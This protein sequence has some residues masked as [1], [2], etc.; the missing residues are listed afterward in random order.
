DVVA[1]RTNGDRCDARPRALPSDTTP[2]AARR[3]V[4]TCRVKRLGWLLW[5]DTLTEARSL[6]RLG[7]L[8]LF[9]IVTL[10]T[11]SFSLPVDSSAR[12]LVGAGF[13]WVAIVFASVLEFRRSFESERKDGTLDGLRAA[14]LDTTL[15]FI[16]KALST[17][18]VVAVV[19][20][21]L[22]PLTALFFSG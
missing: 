6:E 2:D 8:V 11:L 13:I 9:A 21:A 12:K 15:L 18:V 4:A 5:K 22:V 19:T 14:P 1:R 3:S 16:A 7:T 10:L 17:F 20:G